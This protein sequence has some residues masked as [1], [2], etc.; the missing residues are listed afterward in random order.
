MKRTL[1]KLF[2]RNKTSRQL[3][4]K[5][6]FR[7]I[8]DTLEQRLV[9]NGDFTTP[10]LP[11]DD[12][13]DIE[14]DVLYIRGTNENDVIT[15]EIDEDDTD[16]VRVTV[17]QIDGWNL[18]ELDSDDYDID[19]FER[20]EIRGFDGNDIIANLTNLDTFM[21]GGNGNDDMYSGGGN[22]VMA[23]EAG[24]DDYEFQHEMNSL[25][26]AG[27]EY[28]FANLG[29]DTII[30]NVGEGS[31]DIRLRELEGAANLDLA[32][33][34]L[35]TVSAGRLNLTVRNDVNQ[36]A[37]IERV[38]GT[39]FDDTILGN[40]FANYLY[41][42]SGDDELVGRDGNDR[43]YGGYDNDTLEGQGGDDYLSGSSGD[44][45][46]VFN[47]VVTADLGTDDIRD[48]GN[49][50][51]DIL[52]FSAMIMDQ[53]QIGI[54][55]DLAITGDQALDFGIY[56][57]FALSLN[58][59]TSEIEDVKA[60]AG[61]DFV[62]GNDFDNHIWTYGN[63]DTLEGRGGD[64]I[65]EGGSSSDTYYFKNEN[66]SNLGN[67]NI[68]ESSYAD[69][70]TL[71]FQY[72]D[73]GITL[74]IGTTSTQTVAANVLQLSLSSSV[75]IENVYGSQFGD[76]IHGNSRNNTLNGLDGNDWLYGEA[77][78]DLLYGFDGTDRLYGGDH[79]D[80]MYGGNHNDYLYG[81][82]GLDYIYGGDGAD[83][84]NGD[85][86]HS[87]YV[88]DGYNDQLYGYTAY[89]NNDGDRDMF[90]HHRRY[91]YQNGRYTSVDA[92]WET[93]AGFNSSEDIRHY[94]YGWNF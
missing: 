16:E 70:D 76:T 28:Y 81:E 8:L 19:H 30:E 74:D 32:N 23:G 62:K 37:E 64:D 66:G 50:G 44:D 57:P 14:D 38:Y 7:P 87:H 89:S 6:Q 34:N 31:D 49:Q 48:Y 25:K 83:Y 2:T 90:V 45:T 27:V 54:N 10:G 82:G 9:L 42:Y 36:V 55:L 20:I 1:Q 69:T 51:K 40:Q 78:S 85:Y 92:G 47:N 4:A 3:A 91:V 68:V 21:F 59:S 41:G 33:T 46:Y 17:F 52:D 73:R 94:Y 22:D 29:S 61:Y 56:S 13:S 84:L 43:L 86:S 79:N 67:D 53:Y 58:L 75:G 60:T 15:I 65:L 24:N 12:M 77:G 88:S 72:M 63:A 5:N 18:L 11:G 93:L 80:T 26:F 71:N 39:D 35:Q